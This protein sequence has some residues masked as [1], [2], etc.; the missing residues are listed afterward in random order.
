MAYEE[1]TACT[2]CF[3]SLEH[4]HGVFGNRAY[5][6]KHLKSFMLDRPS[7]WRATLVS[8]GSAIALVLLIAIATESLSFAPQGITRTIINLAFVLLPPLFWLFTFY[9]EDNAVPISILAVIIVSA[10]V[11]AALARPFLLGVIQLEQWLS[12]VPANSRLLNH[13]LLGG[14]THAFLMYAT[15]RYTVWRT[16]SFQRQMD[17]FL[18]GMLTGWGYG[19]TANILLILDHGSV[20]PLNGGMQLLGQAFIFLTGGIILGYYLGRNRFEDLPPYYL[21]LG[22]GLATLVMGVGFY[23]SHEL[24][25]GRLNL[26]RDGYSPWPG[27]IISLVILG[28]SFTL[29]Y[30]LMRRDNAL[31][32]TRIEMEA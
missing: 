11:E 3:E 20:T 31:A 22:V 14:M 19:T 25:S 13:I 8:I 5:C 10:L 29:A 9:R 2:V 7:L 12:H 16:P 1:L 32:R 23:A 24:N 17:G 26:T 21:S 18:Y 28:T 30:V 27:G 6:P 4:D 15:V